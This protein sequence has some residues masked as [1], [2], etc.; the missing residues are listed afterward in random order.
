[1][2]IFVYNYLC[3][4]IYIFGE[5]SSSLQGIL[6]VDCDIFMMLFAER[7]ADECAEFFTT[8]TINKYTNQILYYIII[9]ITTI[10]IMTVIAIIIIIVVI[11]VIMIV[12][13]IIKDNCFL[14]LVVLFRNMWGY[15]Y[16]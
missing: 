10:I 5:Y 9:I 8:N 12:I 15:I 7:C 11:I 4:Y 14:L 1:M 2:M 16:V 3:I 6:Y 13:V